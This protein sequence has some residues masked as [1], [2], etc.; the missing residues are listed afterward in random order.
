MSAL[1]SCFFLCNIDA[2]ITAVLLSAV[3]I[4]DA[5]V[6]VTIKQTGIRNG[7]K[8]LSESENR[9]CKKKNPQLLMGKQFLNLSAFSVDRV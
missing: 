3:E 6:D 1:C 9:I 5:E 7:G 2:F 8:R 4:S